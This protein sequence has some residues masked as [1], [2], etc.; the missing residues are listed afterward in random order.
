MKHD[1]TDDP[2]AKLVPP[3]GGDDFPDHRAPPSA[4]V[5]AF[6]PSVKI[7]YPELFGEPESFRDNALGRNIGDKLIRGVYS[8]CFL[9]CQAGIYYI[10]SIFVGAVCSLVCGCLYGA[11]NLC[12]VWCCQPLLKLGFFW[13]RLAGSA[14][15]ALVRMLCEPCFQAIG[16]SLSF[17]RGKFRMDVSGVTFTTSTQTYNY[18]AIESGE[19]ETK[20]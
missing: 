7:E 3:P 10:L 20:A 8:N 13:L 16:Q 5:F 1:P 15:R 12:L 6:G 4:D 2:S 19:A 9:Y 14:N 18:G 17:I 11:N